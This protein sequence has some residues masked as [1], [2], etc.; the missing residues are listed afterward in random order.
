MLVRHRGTL[1][2][3]VAAVAVLLPLGWLWKTSLLPSTYS[4]MDMGYA[5]FGV[6]RKAVATDGH[7]NMPGM[8]HGA[9]VASLTGPKG[10]TADVNVTLVARKQQFRLPSGESVSGY[11]FNGTSPGPQIRAVQGQLVK[12]RLVNRSVPDGVT[13]H[14]HGLDVPNAEDGVSGVTQDAVRVGGSYTYQFV[15][16][17]AGTFWYHSHQVSHEQVAG[18]LL[19]PIVIAPK[20]AAVSRGPRAAGTG[21]STAPAVDQLAM[22]HLY[23]GVRTV[24]GRSGDTRIAASPGSR[25][26]VRVINSDNGPMSAWV[27]GSAYRLVAVDGTDLNKPTPVTDAAVMVTAGGRADLEVQV[28][29]DG[30]AVRVVLGGKAALVL[31]PTAGPAPPKGGRPKKT[32]DL[33][34]YGSPTA[35]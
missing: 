33:L 19:G 7:Q 4:V 23:G 20:P 12:V 27:T 3:A 2:A 31:G 24:N 26:R 17:Q 10:R 13:L 21:T 22:V 16:K 14:W 5:D 25:V 32:L 9:S 28:P 8:A 18:G 30:S 1:L 11:T 15:V 6:G 29:A 35:V 34:T